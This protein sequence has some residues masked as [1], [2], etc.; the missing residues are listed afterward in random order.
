MDVPL[1]F[2]RILKGGVIAVC[3]AFLA[4]LLWASG[5]GADQ[6]PLYVVPLSFVIVIWLGFYGHAV[7]SG[8]R[9]AWIGF[10]ALYI[11]LTEV[12]LRTRPI[13]AGGLDWQVAMKLAVWFGG[14]FLA[15]LRINSVIE[16]LRTPIGAATMIFMGFMMLS[17]IWAPDPGDSIVS[18][19]LL[20]CTLLFAMAMVTELAVK[21]ILIG[22][23]I[24]YCLVVLPSL[25][26]SP[27]TASF[28][29]V[30]ADSLGEADRLRG[31]TNHPVSLAAICAM[32]MV[33][34][35]ALML[36]FPK[37]R[38]VL[39]GLIVLTL[40]TLMLSQSRM[41]LVAVLASGLIFWLR[42]RP[43]ASWLI[44]IGVLAAT[45]VT[46]TTASVGLENVLP[47]ELVK[48][49]SRSGDV[50]ELLTLTGRSVIWDFTLQQIGDAPILGHGHNSSETIFLE[51]F[52]FF[53]V[54]HAHN[55]ILQSLFSVGI[56]GTLFLVTILV[57]QLRT[58]L[59]SPD[60]FRDVML[61]ALLVSGIT[62]TAFYTRLPGTLSIIWM[63][64]IALGAYYVVE[65]RR[66]DAALWAGPG[67]MEEGISLGAGFGTD[68]A[69]GSVIQPEGKRLSESLAG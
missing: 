27:F 28:A 56:V 3:L 23:T 21:D 18:S 25:A 50:N 37:R 47:K 36:Y 13:G 5:A 31:F 48:L 57:I 15:M 40:A 38:I 59:I 30:N 66:I 65:R 1:G 55:L 2:Q 10:L 39:A 16:L 26:I 67:G 32:L 35:A 58:F 44:P 29:P 49:V 42:V 61:L 45:V 63:F 9:W 17:S 11:F 33:C 60:L 51:R 7:V 20:F 54:T 68:R 24:G 64:T 62:E 53:T 46:L 12:N 14:T 8:R 34:C 41:A 43:G 19:I 69:S 6:V 22:L 52:L 4:V